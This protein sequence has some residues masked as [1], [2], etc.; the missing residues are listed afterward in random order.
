MVR[1]LRSSDMARIA[2]RGCAGCGDCCT[3][4]G[5]TIHL[6][7][8]DVCFLCAA[9]GK[10][11]SAM[12]NEEIALHVEQGLIL[13]HLQMRR[14]SGRCPFLGEDRRCGI[15]E[16]RPGICRLFPLG[17]N[18]D[19]EGMQ[20]FVVEGGCDMPGKSRVQ[21]SRWLG[22]KDLA[23]YENFVPRW[24]YFVRRLQER[25]R[26]RGDQAYARE[27]SMRVLRLFY[28]VPWDPDAFYEQFS[29]RLERFERSLEE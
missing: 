15:Y 14:D 2:T 28:L 11:F 22:V 24:H 17:R 4:M 10:S 6:D 5:D 3:G 9:T 29:G 26:Q 12:M 20:Y 8:W 19:G 1:L 13:P 16:Q 21:V 23:R 7:P 18:F 27:L 25:I